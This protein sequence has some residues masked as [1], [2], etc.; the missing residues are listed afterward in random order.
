M[1]AFTTDSREI[2]WFAVHDALPAAWLVGPITFDP[3]RGQFSVRAG[4]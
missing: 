3:G 1:S 4:L 2:A